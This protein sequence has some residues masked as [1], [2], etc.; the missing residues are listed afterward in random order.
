MSAA[1]S[2][3]KIGEEAARTLVDVYDELDSIPRYLAFEAWA[4]LEFEPARKIVSNETKSS[5]RFMR[6]FAIITL[7]A[8]DPE[9]GMKRVE[10]MRRSESDLFVLSMMKKAVEIAAAS[11]SED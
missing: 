2:L 9:R 1:A 4:R 6:G 10:E 8:I 11:E 3:V 7:A 5:N